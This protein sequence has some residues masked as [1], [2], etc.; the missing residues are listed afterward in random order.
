MDDKV[1]YYAILPASVRYDNDISASAKLMYAEITALSNKE[2]YC[3]ANNQY[4]ADLYG[5]SKRTITRWIGELTKSGYV[6]LE[7]KYKEDKK[8]VD[9]RKMYIQDKI[10]HPID[11]SVHTY[12][13]ECLL[14][15]D[16]SDY[17]NNI[18]INT[19]I[20]KEDMSSSS[21]NIPMAEV[22]KIVDRW[23]EVAPIKSRKI[24]GDSSRYKE[25]NTI[26]K[27]YGLDAIIEM[28]D[29]VGKSGFLQGTIKGYNGNYFKSCSL[30]WCIQDSKFN[31]ILDG[32][33]DNDKGKGGANGTNW[34]EPTAEE[35]AEKQRE[36]ERKQQRLAE[37]LD[38]EYAKQSRLKEERER[39]RQENQS[40]LW[41]Y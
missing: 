21:K 17:Y 3:W 6:W 11:K 10:D 8:T 33:F 26:Y 32:K 37:E 7:I 29:K 30:N 41:S 23:N 14:P 4:F 22:H 5:V 1:A 40:H 15:I 39:E 2:G 12:R 25:L 24:V 18:S 36:Y 28:I 31:D 34:T 20:N 13:Q 19:I 35:L 38:R 16:K 9:F 27:R